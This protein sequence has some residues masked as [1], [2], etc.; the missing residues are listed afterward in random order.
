MNFL[1][2]LNHG[3]QL[4]GYDEYDWK[5]FYKY[6]LGH[7]V[8]LEVDL[9][10]EEL[11]EEGVKRYKAKGSVAR[12]ISVERDIDHLFIDPDSVERKQLEVKGWKEI[13]D[14]LG[15]GP[16]LTKAQ[17]RDVKQIQNKHW[18]K[19]ERIWLER[20]LKIEYEKCILII[21]ADH[22]DRVRTLM[23]KQKMSNQLL[24][25]DYRGLQ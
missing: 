23:T 11:N 12:R 1:I 10:A 17:S 15:Y 16:V 14:E 7:A 24:V 20:L 8:D 25:R 9:L 6:L 19:R 13:V 18:D 2:G 3:Y 4:E 22:V 5:S 21:G